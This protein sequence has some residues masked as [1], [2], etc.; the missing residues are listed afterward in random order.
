MASRGESGQKELVASQLSALRDVDA[1]VLNEDDLGMKRT[2]CKDVARE[3]AGVLQMNYMY[4]V[5]F[6][7][8]DSI[9]E[10]GAEEVHLPGAQVGARLS[11]DLKVDCQQYGG[12]HGK[13]ILEPLPDR[14]RGRSSVAGV[15]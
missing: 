5:E 12:L 9:F 3:L 15:L 1:L 14:K 7:E 8:V 2:G 11:E 13:A 6:V 4:G 10:P